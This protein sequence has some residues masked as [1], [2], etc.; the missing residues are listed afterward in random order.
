MA[1]PGRAGLVLPGQAEPVSHSDQLKL[2][3]R[4]RVGTAGRTG[5]QGAAGGQ[6]GRPVPPSVAG[7]GMPNVGAVFRRTMHT[8]EAVKNRVLFHYFFYLVVKLNMHN[9]GV[10]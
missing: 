2:A 4:R 1:G 9:V 10:Y 8:P 3:R 5:A 6:E 7:D